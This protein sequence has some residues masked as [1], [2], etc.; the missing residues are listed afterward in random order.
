VCVKAPEQIETQRLI[1]RRPR[2]EDAEAIFSRYAGDR[3]VTR[4]LAWP[5]HESLGATH[6]FLEFSDAE[7]TRWPAGPYLVE[8]REDGRLLGSTG[9]AFE[10]PYRAATGYVFA[11][12]TWGNGY[13]GE[14]LRAIVEVARGVGVVR[15][16]AICHMENPT[17]WRVL[18]KCGFKRE[19]VL[20]RHSEF[21]NLT[22]N[23]PCD[24]LCYALVFSPET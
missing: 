23:E 18:E 10:T 5:R 1:L 12:D 8:A 17:S 14:T 21:P 20:R 15:I 7:W 6:A 24:V 2:R 4:F 19:A 9:L 11:K 16:Y 22:P 3:D 13:A